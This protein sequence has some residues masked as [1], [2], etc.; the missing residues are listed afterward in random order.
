M[1][2]TGRFT[3][4]CSRAA[5][6]RLVRPHSSGTAAGKRCV[7]QNKT[8]PD[9]AADA[10]PD[11]A[12]PWGR[13]LDERTCRT[14]RVVR[15]HSSRT[16]TSLF[17]FFFFLFFSARRRLA[18]MWERIA[19]CHGLLSKRARR[20]QGQAGLIAGGPGLA[21]VAAATPWRARHSCAA[22]TA[23]ACSFADDRASTAATRPRCRTFDRVARPKG[24]RGSR[25]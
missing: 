23:V 18:D 3:A 21:R 15:E 20:P 9:P 13:R 5:W 12:R 16:S 10:W 11:R 6:T 2:E 8:P 19:P 4:R 7:L 17:V 24:G 25:R 22:G 14:W 1:C